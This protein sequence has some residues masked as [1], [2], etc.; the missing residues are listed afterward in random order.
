M[1]QIALFDYDT[2]DAETSTLVQQR[3]DEI[4][5]LMRRTAEDITAIGRKLI[6]VKARLGHGQFLAWL[7]AEFGW[8]RDT[9]NKFMHV[10]SAFPA[11]EMSKISTFV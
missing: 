9:A 7:E 11:V 5:A 10:A 6:E 2:L 1:S 8:H 4:R 3:T